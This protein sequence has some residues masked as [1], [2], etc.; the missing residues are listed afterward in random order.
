MSQ[1]IRTACLQTQVYTLS[2]VVYNWYII[3]EEYIIIICGGLEFVENALSVV[4][5]CDVADP[6]TMSQEV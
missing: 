1:Q 3:I 2:T 5:R 4:H 6:S